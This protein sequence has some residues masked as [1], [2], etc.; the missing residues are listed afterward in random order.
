MKKRRRTGTSL[1]LI[2]FTDSRWTR[3]STR[4]ALGLRGGSS[5]MKKR[6][7]TGTS[8]LLIAFTDSRWTR[9]TTRAALG[10]RGDSSRMTIRRTGTSLLLMDKDDNEGGVGTLKR[11]IQNDEEEKDWNFFTFDRFH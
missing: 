6:R 2:A 5:R 1:L 9:M 8:L 3:M 4:A 7:R 11:L 10:L